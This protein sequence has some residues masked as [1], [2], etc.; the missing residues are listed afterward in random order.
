M[1]NYHFLFLLPDTLMSAVDCKGRKRAKNVAMAYQIMVPKRP[2][3]LRCGI[4]IPRLSPQ[5]GI[6]PLPR[7][8]ANM[9][10]SV[11]DKKVFIARA[12]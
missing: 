6:F 8:C 3:R 9:S 2:S 7:F 10:R 5:L 1:R 11:T 12:H 4:W